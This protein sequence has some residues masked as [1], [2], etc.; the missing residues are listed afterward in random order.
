[1]PVKVFEYIGAGLPIVITPVS[2]AGDMV[3]ELQLG[4]QFRSEDQDEIFQF[5]I[6]LSNDQ[7]LYK[8]YAS[9]VAAH[10]HK[11][12]RKELAVAFAEKINMLF[13][14]STPS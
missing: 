6:A 14:E 1:M 12:S 3:G 2:E 5:I 13:E 11:F 8:Q 7:T 9:N 10:R 4:R